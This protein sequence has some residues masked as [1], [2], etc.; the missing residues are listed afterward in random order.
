VKIEV[1]GAQ[2]ILQVHGAAQPCLIV[3]GL[4][5]GARRGAVALWVGTGT[6]AYFTN[7]QVRSGN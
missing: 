2:S 7:L 1:K 3:N 5:L 4:K 6:E